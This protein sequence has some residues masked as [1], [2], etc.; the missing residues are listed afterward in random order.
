[1]THPEALQAISAQL[2]DKV[3]YSTI[4]NIYDI[5]REF[6]MS[7]YIQTRRDTLERWAP[8]VYETMKH[9]L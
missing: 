3:D 4:S 8:E 2:T 6:A 9:I 7:E 5:V 1:M